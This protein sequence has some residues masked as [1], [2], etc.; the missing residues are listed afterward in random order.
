[1]A[2]QIFEQSILQIRIAIEQGDQGSLEMP[3]A[4]VYQDPLG[5]LEYLELP[6]E[7][8]RSGAVLDLLLELG[9]PKAA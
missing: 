1:M 2:V 4:G 7:G 9:Y 8:A 5:Q 3:P 6:A